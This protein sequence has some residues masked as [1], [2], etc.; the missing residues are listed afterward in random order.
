MQEDDL[1][2]FLSKQVIGICMALEEHTVF[3]I[4]RCK[5]SIAQCEGAQAAVQNI[6]DHFHQK[7]PEVAVE[8]NIDISLGPN[9]S[10][11]CSS[12]KK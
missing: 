3:G 5:K 2:A 6:G 4:I 8:E 7:N 12:K 10:C 1:I 9:A 11:G